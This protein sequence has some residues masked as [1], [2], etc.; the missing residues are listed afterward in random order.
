MKILNFLFILVI[1]KN[2]FEDENLKFSFYIIAYHKEDNF[3][4]FLRKIYGLLLILLF[5]SQKENFEYFKEQ[6]FKVF[7]LHQCQS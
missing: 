6:K 5:I 1:K 3:W 2:I 7:F 4:I